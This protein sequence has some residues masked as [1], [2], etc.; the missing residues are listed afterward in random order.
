MPVP[1]KTHIIWYIFGDYLASIL[2]W[3]ILYFTRRILLSEPITINNHIFLNN[4]FWLGIVFIPLG[5][6]IFYGMVGSYH[7]LYK[8]SRLNELTVTAVCSIVGCTVLF[9]SIVINDP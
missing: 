9:F 8:K 6:L 7:S 2:A 3:V 4:R 5:W 1:K